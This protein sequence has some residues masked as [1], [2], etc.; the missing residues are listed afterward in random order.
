LQ[1]DAKSAENNV[2]SAGDFASHK[3]AEEG[4]A[5]SPY[6]NIKRKIIKNQKPNPK[7]PAVERLG[8]AFSLFKNF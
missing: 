6:V 3:K 1:G 2:E 5:Y 4:L 7:S 8:F